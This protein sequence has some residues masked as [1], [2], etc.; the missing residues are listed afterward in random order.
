M[1]SETLYP[2]LL[3]ILQNKFQQTEILILDK[4][5]KIVRK[6]KWENIKK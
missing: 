5:K 2:S 1:Y 4:K 6:I 3:E